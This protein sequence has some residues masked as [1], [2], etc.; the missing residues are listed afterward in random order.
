MPQTAPM[1]RVDWREL[2]RLFL[3]RTTWYIPFDMRPL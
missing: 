3:R 2:E 1:P